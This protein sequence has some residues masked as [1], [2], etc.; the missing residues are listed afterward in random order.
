MFLRIGRTIFPTR[1][2]KCGAIRQYVTSWTDLVWLIDERITSSEPGPIADGS[3]DSRRSLR[4]YRI[5]FI[6]YARVFAVVVHR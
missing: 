2:D 1:R 3:A 6:I 4:Y 5:R